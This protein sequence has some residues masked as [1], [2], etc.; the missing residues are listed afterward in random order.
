MKRNDTKSETVLYLVRHGETEYNRRSIMQ[1]RTV[2]IPLN[3]VGRRQAALLAERFTDVRLNAIYSS[4][5]Q[6][7]LET[8]EIVAKQHP[9][10]P[11]HAR[12]DLE[13]MSWGDFEGRAK[14]KEVLALFESLNAQWQAGDFTKQVPG[15]ESIAQV[16]SR[17][18]EALR[19]ILGHHAGE[20][21]L[22]VT[23]GRF[24]R[25]LLASILPGF[26]LEKMQEIK[27]L[28][29]GV[30]R[31]RFKG[32]MPSADYLNCTAHLSDVGTAALDG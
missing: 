6:R 13:E 21:V 2:D 24:L 18:I 29:T 8:A 26:G 3:E 12:F 22:V 15:G 27:H 17:G 9:A 11:V 19:H 25:V 23:H 20:T 4:T 14:D 1:G 30:N 5:L 32:S 28:N 31:I 16:Q 7:A 10:V